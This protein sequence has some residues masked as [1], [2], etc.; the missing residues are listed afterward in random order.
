MAPSNRIPQNNN[1]AQRTGKIGKSGASAEYA[2]AA[3]AAAHGRRP[4]GYVVKQDRRDAPAAAS[5]N[6]GKTSPRMTKLVSDEVM[7]KLSTMALHRQKEACKV[8]F[9]NCIVTFWIIAKAILKAKA[10][11]EKEN[12]EFVPNLFFK[13][14]EVKGQP[15]INPTKFNVL[16]NGK[17]LMFQEGNGE[18]DGKVLQLQANLATVMHYFTFAAGG[19]VTRYNRTTYDGDEEINLYRT[20]GRVSYAFGMPLMDAVD[21]FVKEK[22]HEKLVDS[23]FYIRRAA[24]LKAG[25]ADASD[26]EGETA[27][28]DV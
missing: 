1:G 22:P 3:K 4:G 25:E 21:Y 14:F 28:V 13:S 23:D 20:E 16:L 9:N 2:A 8:Y 15:R 17:K 6:D 7:I 10:E 18:T 11:A 26:N 24:A 5:S 12:K 19:L 27:E